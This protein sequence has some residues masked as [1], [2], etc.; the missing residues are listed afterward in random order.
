M[1]QL[2]QRAIVETTLRL[3]ERKPL[4]KITVRDIVEACG[5]T[6]NTFYY[7]FHDIYEVLEHALSFEFE[8]LGESGEE[9][10][11]EPLISA[12]HFCI[13][14]KNVLFNLYRSIGYE[15]LAQYV[16]KQLHKLL[17]K[18]ICKAVGERKIEE[19]DLELI[20]ML[21]EEAITGALMRVITDPKR[22]VTPE[23]ADAVI[24]RVRALF[25]GELSRILEKCEGSARL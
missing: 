15:E 21:C 16:K 19:R 2:T 1:S 12:L 14:Y 18:R 25:D 22:T 13:T 8:R 4:N 24:E 23:E 6:R 17:Q 10:G 11:E 5:I 9:M 7:H 3:V 20:C